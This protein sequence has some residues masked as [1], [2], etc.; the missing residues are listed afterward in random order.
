MGSEIDV[1]RAVILAAGRGTRLG[2][3]TADKPKPMVPIQGVPVLEHILVG[4]KGVGIQRFLLVIGYRGA[5]IREYFGDGSRWSM[6][7]EY[8]E[9]QQLNG[10]G[11]AADSGARRSSSLTGTEGTS[12][13]AT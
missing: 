8:V 2:A 5:V 3:I 4:L 12:S 6:G 11:G 7:I 1:K 10:T 13:R 9:Q